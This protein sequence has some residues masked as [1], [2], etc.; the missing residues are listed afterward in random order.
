MP[1]QAEK[2][3]QKLS[4]I[5]ISPQIKITASVLDSRS[6]GLNRT[7]FFFFFPQILT[8]GVFECKCWLVF[9]ICKETWRQLCSRAV[10][11]E[12]PTQQITKKKKKKCDSLALF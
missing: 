1:E 6:D 3:L 8:D 9:L 11:S 7:F 2:R 12:D 10:N 5:A 4:R